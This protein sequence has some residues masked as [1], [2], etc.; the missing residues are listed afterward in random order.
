M[1][2]GRKDVGKPSGHRRARH[3]VFCFFSKLNDKYLLSLCLQPLILLGFEDRLLV[4]VSWY[5]QHRMCLSQLSQPFW[6]CMV[7][8]CCFVAL[9]D[10]VLET[11]LSAW[12]I[13]SANSY[14]ILPSLRKPNSRTFDTNI[15]FLLCLLMDVWKLFLLHPFCLT[16]RKLCAKTIR[17]SRKGVFVVSL[18]LEGWL[19]RT[20]NQEDVPRGL[21]VQSLSFQNVI[22]AKSWSYFELLSA[23]ANNFGWSGSFSEQS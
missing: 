15:F 23:H 3:L 13:D 16:S 4:M 1:D 10:E 12:T 7:R 21:D 5:H 20:V 18:V 9:S 11:H 19:F 14:M 22:S 17:K 6:S 8:K 2:W